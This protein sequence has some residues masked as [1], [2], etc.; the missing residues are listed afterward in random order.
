MRRLRKAAFVQRHLITGDI[1]TVAVGWIL[2]WT[3]NRD[4]RVPG[5]RSVNQALLPAD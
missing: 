3:L 4:I 1:D 2:W 5:E